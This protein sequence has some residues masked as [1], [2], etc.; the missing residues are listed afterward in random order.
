MS[1]RR[2]VE[3]LGVRI[4]DRGSCETRNG[5]AWSAEVTLS[6]GG[7][8]RTF[9]V[10]N[11]GNGGCDDW[12]ELK[13]DGHLFAHVDEAQKVIAVLARREPALAEYADCLASDE[14][15]AGLWVGAALDG[16]FLIETV[17]R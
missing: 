7:K 16:C 10:A 14:A 2:T 9:L 8:Q 17:S 12:T 6:V 3:R 15:A 1:K 11:S 13:A 4:V 5:I